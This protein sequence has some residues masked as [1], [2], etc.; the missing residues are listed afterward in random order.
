M[1]I[2]GIFPKK[3]IFA[4]WRNVLPFF[5]L[6]SYFSDIFY[7]IFHIL[8]FLYVAV[9]KYGFLVLKSH[10]KH[11]YVFEIRCQISG[12]REES[13]LQRYKV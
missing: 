4:Y 11:C 2:A 6:F 9:L 10:A 1:L 3:Y 12:F 7:Q 8:L 13:K 5:S